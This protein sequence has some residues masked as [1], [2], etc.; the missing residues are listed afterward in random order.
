MQ[1]NT[2]QWDCNP[3]GAAVTL[4]RGSFNAM[5]CPI[6]L[7]DFVK[8]HLRS[9]YCITQSWVISAG[10]P[11]PF[12]TLR[13]ILMNELCSRI[14]TRVRRQHDPHGHL[15]LAGDG[16]G[17]AGHGA[18]RRRGAHEHHS[19]VGRRRV[20]HGQ[21]HGGV[22]RGGHAGLAGGHV[23]LRP[24]SARRRLPPNGTLLLPS[25]A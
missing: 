21:L 6:Y 19:S 5:L 10:T 2:L 1:G 11:H 14:S 24:V 12:V 22:R 16:G 23:R 15:P 9:H 4:H 3:T 25:F 8:Q 13:I 20:P 17:G 7:F 18:G